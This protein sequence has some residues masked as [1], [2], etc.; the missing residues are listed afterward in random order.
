MRLL[1]LTKYS[2]AGPSSRYR[3]FQYLPYLDQAGLVY[4]VAPLFDNAYLANRY[5]SG[6]GSATDVITGLLRRVSSLLRLWLTGA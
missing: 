1:F 3:S 6:R 2:Q 4:K 5:G